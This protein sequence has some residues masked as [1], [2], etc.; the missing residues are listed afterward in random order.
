MYQYK[1]NPHNRGRKGHWRPEM[2]EQT[3]RLCLLGLTN[4]ELAEFFGVS[5]GTID[6]WL[7]HNKDFQE[8][9]SSG[10]KEADSKVARA[11][12]QRAI[13]YNAPDTYITVIDKQIV[14]EPITKHY[15]PDPF[16]C[17]KWLAIRQKDKWADVQKTELSYSGTLKIEHISSEISDP[18]KF[19]TEELK[20]ALKL[21]LKQ[22]LNPE[23]ARN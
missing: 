3:F 4:A 14:M 16:A 7:Q 18:E 8:A 23:N 17:I 6:Y 5:S 20:L 2:K 19:S 10:R 1:D 12:Y 22:A 9:V 21:G 13:G 11:L 15:P